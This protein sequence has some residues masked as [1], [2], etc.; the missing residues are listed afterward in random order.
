MLSQT[1]QTQMLSQTPQTQMMSQDLDLVTVTPQG[2]A[3][4]PLNGN[5]PPPGVPMLQERPQL[6]GPAPAGAP[7]TFGT[8]QASSF[9]ALQ[10]A[11]ARQDMDLVTVTPQGL[12]VTPLN[13]NLPPAGVPFLGPGSAPGVAGYGHMPT[14]IQAPQLPT[15]QLGPQGAAWPQ[16]LR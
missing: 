2:L 1:P 14:G 6:Q 15:G 13:G 3:V 16:P 4:T 11:G 9:A 7:H 10:Q 12:A 5:P 8:S